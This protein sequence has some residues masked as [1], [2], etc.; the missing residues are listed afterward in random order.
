MPQIWFLEGSSELK[1][2]SNTTL[3][4]LLFGLVDFGLLT[5]VLA[6]FVLIVLGL[7]LFPISYILQ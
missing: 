7:A 2:T 6:D 3:G 1:G 5:R 4:S